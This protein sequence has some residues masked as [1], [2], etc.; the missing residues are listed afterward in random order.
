[1]NKK[2]VLQLILDIWDKT[3]VYGE[4]NEDNFEEFI[5]QVRKELSKPSQG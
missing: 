1:M 3:T 5:R 2:Q 4:E